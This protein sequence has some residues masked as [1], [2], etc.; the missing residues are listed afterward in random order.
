MRY[1]RFILY[2]ACCALLFVFACDKV[3]L[4][5]DASGINP[6]A[7]PSITLFAP[8]DG[9]VADHTNKFVFE[10]AAS[11]PYVYTIFISTSENLGEPTLYMNDFSDL[12]YA[13]EWFVN[14]AL[15]LIA[16]TTKA[17][18]FWAVC[19]RQE[20][21]EPSWNDDDVTTIETVIPNDPDDE[22][23]DEIEVTYVTNGFWAVTNAVWSVTNVINPEL[24]PLS[25]IISEV[26]YRIKLNSTKYYSDG[27]FVEIHN[28]SGYSVDVG[29]WTIMSADKDGNPNTVP[30]VTIP[31]GNVIKPKGFLVI[32]YSSKQFDYAY[33][34]YAFPCVRLYLP[35]ASVSSKGFDLRLLDRHGTEQDH[36]NSTQGVSMPKEKATSVQPQYC[37]Y[38][39]TL[40]IADGMLLSSWLPATRAGNG[41]ISEEGNDWSEFTWATPGEA[42]SVWSGYP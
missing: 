7:P 22:T 16:G 21:D 29:G 13:Q 34:Q 15:P 4:Q 18:V 10:W 24:D 42:N 8:R 28:A 32:G 6:N 31:F 36:C 14:T 2:A 20:G 30:S 26:G 19:G 38:E 5:I 11:V 35:I 40:P 3:D 37:S 17:R 23:D 39:R 41:V 33:N 1:I 25:V 27:D 9:I 12:S